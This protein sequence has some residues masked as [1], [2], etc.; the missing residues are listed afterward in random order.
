M[1]LLSTSDPFPVTLTKLFVCIASL[2]SDFKD[3]TL[4]TRSKMVISFLDISGCCKQ[5]GYVDLTY[6]PVY[7]YVYN[8]KILKNNSLFKIY[9]SSQMAKNFI[10]AYLFPKIINMTQTHVFFVPLSSF[11]SHLSVYHI[12]TLKN[13]TKK[14]MSLFKNN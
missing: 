6:I 9:F 5:F 13:K 12:K 10:P 3:I 8:F 2:I 1:K 4:I 11:G 14:R 7:I